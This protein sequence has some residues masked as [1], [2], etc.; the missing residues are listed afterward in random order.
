MESVLAMK[1]FIRRIVF[2]PFY[3]LLFI[4]AVFTAWLSADKGDEWFYFVK[5]LFIELWTGKDPIDRMLE[6]GLIERK[7]DNPPPVGPEKK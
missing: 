6:E 1:N 7:T 2:L 5:D 3:P 4:L